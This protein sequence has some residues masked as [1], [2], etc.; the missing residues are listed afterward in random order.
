MGASA[1]ATDTPY[2]ISS[3]E[4]SYVDQADATNTHDGSSLSN[5][6]TVNTQYRDWTTN[7]WKYTGSISFKN[8]AGKLALYKFPLSTVKSETG[9][10]KSATFTF[11]VNSTGDGNNVTTFRA[12]GYTGS[13]DWTGATLT[14]NTISNSGS[15][16]KGYTIDY[17]GSFAFLDDIADKSGGAETVISFDALTFTASVLETNA[18]YITFAVCNNS[19][20]QANL[21]VSATLNLV[22]TDLTPFTYSVNAVEKDN[23]SNIL[24]TYADDLTGYQ[25]EEY[26]IYYNKCIQKDGTWYETTTKNSEPYLGV[27]VT[28]GGTTNVEYTANGANYFYEFESLPTARSNGSGGTGDGN[29]PGR[30]SNGVAKRLYQYTRAYTPALTGGVYTIRLRAHNTSSSGAQN[31]TLYLCDTSGNISGEQIATF[32]ED[33]SKATLDEKSISDIVIPDGSSLAIF[34]NSGANSNLCIDYFILTRDE[35]KTAVYNAILDCKTFE[36]SSDFATYIDGL[37]DAGSLL[38]AAQVYAAHTAW[39]I[40]QGTVT[41]GVRDIT[42]VIRNAAVND[43]AATDWTGGSAISISQEYTGA[44]DGYFIDVNS[45]TINAQQWLYGVPTGVYTIKAATRS[46]ET[47]DKGYLFVNKNGEGDIATVNINHDGN[48]GGELGNG[49]SWSEAT[50]TLTETSNLLIGFYVPALETG[51]WAGCDD[52]HLYKVESVSATITSAGWATLYTPYALDFSGVTGLEAYTAA[53]SES[54]VTLTKVNN[55]PAG[56]GVVLKGAANTYNIPVIASSTTD[57][58][59]LLGSATEATDYNAYDGYTL[60]MLKMVNEKAQFVPMTSGS[61]AAGKAY[62]K[63]AS[64][65]SSTARS[66]NVVFADETTGIQTVQ[67]EGIAVDGYFNLSGQR[68]S[69]PTKGL[70]IVNGKKIIVK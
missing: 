17:E 22:Y 16:S 24:N 60:Y 23:T 51:Q 58:G 13:Q 32:A 36:T 70:Y 18:D 50:F 25:G 34:N 43:A 42:K 68:V 47:T 39:Q 54:A 8:N 33:W 30:Y 57:K 63:I 3:S 10:L 61:L 53:V 5:L 41:D 52:W 6:I 26:T 62:L 19:T 66:L 11:T 37:Y 4:S 38:T 48:T 40:E 45:T 21:N 59:H 46:I 69:Q 15:L 9:T 1:W 27:K 44:P 35:A 56:T 67:G 65:A 28:T 20:R 31:A 55:V 2:N 12:V 7:N 64:G 29:A 49:W 14:Y